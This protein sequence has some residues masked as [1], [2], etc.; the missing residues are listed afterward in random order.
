MRLGGG[1][2]ASAVFLIGLRHLF[3]MYLDSLI[4]RSMRMTLD[5]EKS[6]AIDT[7]LLLLLLSAS[8]FFSFFS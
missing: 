4:D 3:C 7:A 6:R 8:C 1:L 5:M 2:V